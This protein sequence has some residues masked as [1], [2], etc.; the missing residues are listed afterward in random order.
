LKT[1]KERVFSVGVGLGPN[2]TVQYSG[3]VYIKLW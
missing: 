2:N 1:K 3:G